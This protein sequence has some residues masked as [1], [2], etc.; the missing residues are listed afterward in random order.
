MNTYIEVNDQLGVDYYFVYLTIKD[1]VLQLTS[2]QGLIKPIHKRIKLS[3]IKELRMEQF[4]G[5]Q[6]LC[7][8]YENEEYRFFECGK[9]VIDYLQTS[10]YG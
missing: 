8:T 10:I 4:F 1:E 6:R 5:S 3:E 9:G 2:P 7:F